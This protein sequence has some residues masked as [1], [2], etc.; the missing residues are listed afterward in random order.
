MLFQCWPT[1]FDAGPTLT[2]H[3]VNAPCLLGLIPVNT[4]QESIV[5]PMPT[6]DLTLKQQWV[7]VLCLL[8]YWPGVTDG[9]RGLQPVAG[10]HRRWPG[11]TDGG[12]T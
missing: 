10:G 1:V 7:N 5:I 12:I 9:G 2:Q 3:W 8:R 6:A 4:I 11:V